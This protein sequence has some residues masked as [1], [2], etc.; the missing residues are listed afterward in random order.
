[1]MT[2]HRTR[3]IFTTATEQGHHFTL[4]MNLSKKCLY[5]Y[6]FHHLDGLIKFIIVL[7][8]ETLGSWTT[9]Y[10]NLSK[11]CL[12]QSGGIIVVGPEDLLLNPLHTTGCLQKQIQYFDCFLRFPFCCL[13]S[14][15]WV[16]PV[17]VSFHIQ[18]CINAKPKDP[19]MHYGQNT[20]WA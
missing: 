10:D 6:K 17:A 4:G 20:C 2:N 16:K 15:P 7:S 9:C 1:M 5:N 11:W 12:E 3:N 14:W 18:Q 19:K 13:R 8:L